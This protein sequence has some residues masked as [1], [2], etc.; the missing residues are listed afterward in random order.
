MVKRGIMRAVRPIH[1]PLLTLHFVPIDH[2]HMCNLVVRIRIFLLEMH[3]DRF[4]GLEGADVCILAVRIKRGIL[5]VREC[6]VADCGSG[7]LGV[8]FV[9]PVGSYVIADLREH[10]AFNIVESKAAVADHL[11]CFFQTYCPQAEAV[12]GIALHVSFDPGLHALIV[13][14]IRIVAHDLLICQHLI[15]SIEIVHAHLTKG[16]SFCLKNYFL[17]HVISPLFVSARQVSAQI[18]PS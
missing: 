10:L 17:C 5:G 1:W 18:S 13:K 12:V 4:G 2:G 3:A 11:A 7:F 14:G 6:P 9:L 16:E 8:A 15:Q